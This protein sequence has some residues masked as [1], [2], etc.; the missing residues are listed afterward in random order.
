[1]SDT[2]KETCRR[3]RFSVYPNNTAVLEWISQQ[4]NLSA[5]LS[6]IIVD[7]IQSYGYKDVMANDTESLGKV[8]RGRPPKQEDFD[9]SADLSA[10]NGIDYD[11]LAKRLIP[12]LQS[13]SPSFTPQHEQKSVKPHANNVSPTARSAASFFGDD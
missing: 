10:N 2:K 6:H 11:E 5:S 7:A 13:Q 9:A 8:K 4:M 3:F 12:L 1:M